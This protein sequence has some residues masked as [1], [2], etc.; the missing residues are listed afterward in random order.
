[1]YIANSL[2]YFLVMYINYSEKC[3]KKQPGLLYDSI[4]KLQ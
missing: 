1:M 3:K 4:A 2:A